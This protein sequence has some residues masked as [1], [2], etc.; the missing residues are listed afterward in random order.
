VPK[1]PAALPPQQATVAPPAATAPA[2][3]AAP[4][5]SDQQMRAIRFICRHEFANNCRGVP[6]GGAEAIACLQRNPGKLTPDCKTSLAALGDAMPPAAGPLPPPA[7]RT[8]NAPVVMTAV[9]GRRA[10]AIC[11]CTAA[12]QASATAKRSPA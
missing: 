9:I 3:E 1:Q 12:I 7:T 2:T 10:C 4:A 11:S 8:P 6:P 5:P